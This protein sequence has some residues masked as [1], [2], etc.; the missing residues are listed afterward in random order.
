MLILICCKFGGCHLEYLL[1]SFRFNA[2][3][4]ESFF[5]FS[6]RWQFLGL[7]FLFQALPMLSQ[8]LKSDWRFQLLSDSMDCC[9]K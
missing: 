5:Y 3:K 7:V 8:Q 1:I 4:C 9:V 2:I 6:C